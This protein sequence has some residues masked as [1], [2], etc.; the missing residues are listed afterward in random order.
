M[1]RKTNYF[2]I[3]KY[4]DFIVEFWKFLIEIKYNLL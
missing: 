2:K 4:T 3:L 1:T